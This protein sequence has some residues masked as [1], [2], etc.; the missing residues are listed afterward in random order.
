MDKVLLS[1]VVPVYRG[2][3]YLEEL[4]KRL[5][6]VR[7]EIEASSLPLRLV[8]AVFV[9]DSAVDDSTALLEELVEEHEWI[10]VVHLSRN[11]GQHPATVAGVLHSSG[12]WV[13]TL[14]EDLQ[15]RPEDLVPLLLHAVE[16]GSDLVYAQPTG[17]V[18]RRLTRDLASR[19]VKKAT[20]WLTGNPA[21]TLFSSFRMIRGSVARAA[22]SVVSHDTY[23]DSALSWF[24]D[25]ISSWPLE[26]VDRRARD[27][28][29]SGYSFWSLVSHAW[30]LVMSAEIKILR[31]GALVGL[32][33]L[34]IGMTGSAVV[35]A[36]KL[37]DPDSIAVR[38]WA[39]LFLA[40]LFF[41]GLTSF[42][43]GGILEFLTT[44]V[45][46]S[47]GKP[48]FFIVDRQKDRLLRNDSSHQIDDPATNR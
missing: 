39:S 18:H 41:G 30:R 1:V 8:E 16:T 36:R 15:H 14:D 9:D 26:I 45:L 46:S 3:A 43:A 42:L 21:V 11:F 31:L 2:E 4:V 48:T 27:G 13:A 23:F 19:L 17:T 33:A 6:I 44:V 20:A 24:T 10:S 7:S 47:K 5:S 29:R 38:G 40:V 32:V 22:A 37:I 34:I 35:I 12:D 25:R 28:R